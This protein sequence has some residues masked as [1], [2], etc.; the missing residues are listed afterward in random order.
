MALYKQS[1]F[2]FLYHCAQTRQGWST[3]DGMCCRTSQVVMMTMDALQSS[4]NGVK[5]LKVTQYVRESVPVL[6]RIKY[7]EQM[8]VS[9][10]YHHHGLLGQ[11]AAHENT[12]T[13]CTYTVK[14]LT[15]VRR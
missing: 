14:T 4:D 15:N 5:S 12:L 3:L 1:F 9:K 2:P 11:K 7:T 13:R 6:H 10:Q 8:A